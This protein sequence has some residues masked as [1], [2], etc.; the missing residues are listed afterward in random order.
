MRLALGFGIRAGFG[1][2]QSAHS[3]TGAAN[4][5]VGRMELWQLRA[6]IGPLVGLAFFAGLLGAA[7]GYALGQAEF[8]L[9]AGVLTF[10]LGLGVAR[11]VASE[12]RVRSL[13]DICDATGLDP[14][15][16]A[17]VVTPRALRTLSPDARTP[18]AIVLQYPASPFAEAMRALRASAGVG[19]RG[20]RQTIALTSAMPGEGVTT[21]ALALARSFSLR[22]QP[23]IVLDC[24]LRARGLTRAFDIQT[25]KG[26]FEAASGQEDWQRLV[27]G[28]PLSNVH[29]LPAAPAASALQ[30]LYTLP[31]FASLLTDLRARYD[32]IVLDCPCVLGNAEAR[33]LAEACDCA[34]LVSNWGQAPLNA[35][36][37][38]ADALRQTGRAQVPG[39][40]VNCGPIDRAS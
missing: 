15:A 6:A 34:V 31:G 16:I 1:I 12:A 36:R 32:L 24:D 2:V 22:N 20:G 26:V 19:R 30:E 14:L 7:V 21:T 28:D 37:T 33:M 5:S 11:K 10:L 13:D 18:S 40:F 8:G 4:G 29:I 9:V 23:V 25:Q 3:I 17:P 38:A 27:H 35:L 39:V